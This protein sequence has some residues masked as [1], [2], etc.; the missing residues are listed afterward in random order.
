MFINHLPRMRH[1]SPNTKLPILTNT[2]SLYHC[3]THLLYPYTLFTFTSTISLLRNHSLYVTRF[4][5][6]QTPLVKQARFYL[7]TSLLFYYHS[8][9]LPHRMNNFTSYHII[10]FY[11]YITTYSSMPILLYTTYIDLLL[12]QLCD[13][14]VHQYDS[15]PNH[16]YYTISLSKH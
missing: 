8:K 6:H 2:S 10:A 16:Y 15:L 9:T 13:S 3:F 4:C 1:S 11:Q 5:A 14:S 7:I 12:L